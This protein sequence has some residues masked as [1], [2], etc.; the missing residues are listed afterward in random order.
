MPIDTILTLSA[1]GAVFAS[2]AALLVY[3][4]LTWSADPAGRD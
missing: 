4:D 3:A 1:I 2:F